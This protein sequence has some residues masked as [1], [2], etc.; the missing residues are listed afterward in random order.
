MFIP[1][2]VNGWIAPP[3]RLYMTSFVYDEDVYDEDVYD[4]NVCDEHVYDEHVY[5]EH[6]YDEHVYDETKHNGDTCLENHAA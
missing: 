4:E 5:D 1:T 3:Q 2:A 6:V